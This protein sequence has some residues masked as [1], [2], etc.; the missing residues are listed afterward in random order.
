MPVWLQAQ[1]PIRKWGAAQFRLS[2]LRQGMPSSLHVAMLMRPGPMHQ[3]DHIYILLPDARL[4]PTFPEFREIS[5]TYL[6]AN[7]S[8]LVGDYQAFRRLFPDV[9]LKPDKFSE[10]ANSD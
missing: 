6:P 4:M 3:D 1:L 5:Q 9:V 8:M 7:L 2:M 10:P